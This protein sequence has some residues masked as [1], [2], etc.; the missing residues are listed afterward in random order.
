MRLTHQAREG[1]AAGMRGRSGPRGR[2]GQ[3][4]DAACFSGSRRPRD[5]GGGGH[6]PARLLRRRWHPAAAHATGRRGLG[7]PTGVGPVTKTVWWSATPW[8]RAKAWT[9]GFGTCRG[10]C[11]SRSSGVA[12]RR[13]CASPP[14]A[15]NLTVVPRR[16]LRVDHPRHRAWHPDGGLCPGQGLHP[17]RRVRRSVFTRLEVLVGTNSGTTPGYGTAHAANCRAQP[18]P[19][20]PVSS[21]TCGVARSGRRSTKRR[22]ATGS[23]GRLLSHISSPALDRGLRRV[24][25]APAGKRYAPVGKW[26]S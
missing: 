2:N 26:S 18:H 10:V 22:T 7:G 9:R 16:P 14:P 20:G 12:G 1:S 5:P 24:P 21:Q 17:R 23:V 15:S 25:G 6:V 13:R 3:P 11:P 4:V 19:V 8:L